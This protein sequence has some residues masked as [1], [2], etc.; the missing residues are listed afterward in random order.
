MFCWNICVAPT[1]PPTSFDLKVINSTAI[2]ATWDL[3]RINERNGFI[4]GY[5]LFVQTRDG[6]TVMNINIS[7]IDNVIMAYIVDG[8]KR[9]TPYTFSILAYTVADGPRST[10][11]TA[12]TLRK[13]TTRFITA[14]FKL[15]FHMQS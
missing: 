13:S 9:A 1:G 7:D 8:L 6:K 5:K 2:E 4:R 11:L 12:V 15:V 10:Q 3:P 14:I